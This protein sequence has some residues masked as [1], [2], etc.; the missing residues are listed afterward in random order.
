[1]CVISRSNVCRSRV[2]WDS[3]GVYHGCDEMDHGC[4]AEISFVCAQ[5]D[6]LE[7]LELAEEV[8]DQMPPFV[9]FLVDGERVGA[10]RM[11]GDDNLDRRDRR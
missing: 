1:M 11:L 2:C 4:E 3:S 8:F 5:R 7:L 6:A 9:H 10:A